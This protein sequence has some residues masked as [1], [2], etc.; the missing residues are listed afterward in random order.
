MYLDEYTGKGVCIAVID[1]GV[2]AG[3]PHVGGVSGGV[4]IRDDGTLDDDFVDR[5]GHGTAVAAAIREKAPAAEIVAIKVFWRSL[6][7]SVAVLVRAVDEAIAR[8]A[9]VINL[10]LGTADGRHRAELAAAVGRAQA[11]GVRIVSA[12]EDAGVRW[13][14]GDLAGVMPVQLDWSCARDAYRILSEQ[15]RSIIAAS[16]YPRDIPGVPRE[17][18]L[19]GISFAVANASAFVARAIQAAPGADAPALFQALERSA[20]AQ[21]PG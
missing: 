16:G 17:R 14:P 5:L 13:L 12:I 11:A 18:N 6:A 10:S 8:Q 21:L 15:R 20:P 3:H 2:H 19:R 4:A 7:T 1:S 9:A